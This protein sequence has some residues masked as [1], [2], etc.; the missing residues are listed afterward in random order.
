MKRSIG[1]LGPSIAVTLGV[2]PLAGSLRFAARGRAA[3][4]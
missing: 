4:K 1:Y 2:A 3:L